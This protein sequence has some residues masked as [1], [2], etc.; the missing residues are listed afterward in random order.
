LGIKLPIWFPTTK[1]R[2]SP[3]F[4]CVQVM[5][6]IFFKR[7]HWGLQFFFEPHLNRRSTHKIMGLQSCRSPNLGNFE[8]PTW[9]SQ[10]KMTFG[11]RHVQRRGRWWFPWNL[12]CGESCGSVFARGLFVHQKCSNYTLTDLLFGFVQ[13]HVSNW[14]ACHSS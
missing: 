14:L 5:C 7:F 9:E 10:D 6:H 13:V 11:C 2:E 3:W 1:S 12:G 8:T 4:S